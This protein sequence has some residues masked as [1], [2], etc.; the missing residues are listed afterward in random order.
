[1]VEA[2]PFIDEDR[3]NPRFA[4]ATPILRGTPG[5]Y[6]DRGARG[7]SHEPDDWL[8]QAD[9]PERI[10]Q[11]VRE[12]LRVLVGSGIFDVDVTEKQPRTRGLARWRRGGNEEEQ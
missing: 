9:V 11:L 6:A 10:A 5:I 7:R 8:R 4:D 12:D 2:R 3:P 1:M